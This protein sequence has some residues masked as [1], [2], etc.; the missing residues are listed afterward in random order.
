M[1]MESTQI[2]SF[3]DG[4]FVEPVADRYLDNIEP[5]TG[6]PYSLVADSDARDVDLAVAAAEKAFCDW[7][8]KPSAERSRFLLRIADLIERDLEKFARAESIDTGKPIS[9]ARSLD[10]PRAVA[11]FRF[12]A[13]AILHTES[14]AHIT[15]NVAFNYTLRQ[16]RGIAG[17]ISPWN[18]PLYLLSWKI[19]PAVAVGN[20]AIAGSVRSSFANQGQV[21]LCGSRVFVERSAYKD[22]VER[23]IERTAQLRLG[24]PLDENTEQ[25]A[26]VNKTQLEKVKFYVDLAQ[27]E[28][29]KIA[30]GGSA[31]EAP[32]ERCSEGYFF[33]PT[34]ITGLS[35][36]CRTNREEIFGPVVTITPF[37]SEDEVINHANNVE[38]GLSSSVWTQNLSRAHRVA[39]RINTG[40]VWVNCWLVRDLRVPFGGMKQSGVGREGG[41]EALRFFTEP[42]NVCIGK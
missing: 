39:E 37:D 14:E 6:K 42:K 11:N 9:L 8:R 38:Y 3:I 23:F 33:R 15:D 31:P 1:Q 13:T 5:A 30:L 7:S 10:I 41:E 2:K 40:T 27:K 20:A 28:G 21:C 35:V 17:L 22:F 19:A 24:D 26:I 36:S 16:P 32:N 34:V 12:F 18:L 4:Q 25:G 29:G